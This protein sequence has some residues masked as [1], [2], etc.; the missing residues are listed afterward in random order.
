MMDVLLLEVRGSRV[1]DEWGADSRFDGH[2][3]R[4]V[5][6]PDSS[7]ASDDP[8]YLR[9]LFRQTCAHLR[10][11]LLNGIRFILLIGVCKFVHDGPVT[12]C[13]QIEPRPPTTKGGQEGRTD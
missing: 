3:R 8:R 13:Q 1:A 5:K 12:V 7:A 10:P 4:C 11:S 2:C 6:W 9:D